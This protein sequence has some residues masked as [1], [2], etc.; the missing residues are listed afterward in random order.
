[1]S[2]ILC[3]VTFLPKSMHA[4]APDSDPGSMPIKSVLVCTDSTITEELHCCQHLIEGKDMQALPYFDINVLPNN[5][6][7]I[8]TYINESRKPEER[9]LIAVI[10]RALADFVGPERIHRREA[11]EFLFAHRKKGQKIIKWSFEWMCLIL[12]LNPE[13][14]IKQLIKYKYR[15]D[16]SNCPEILH[17]QYLFDN[18]RGSPKHR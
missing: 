13:I 6:D 5:V 16:F 7:F 11:R 14:F 10:L 17:I 3:T 12:N 8:D 2:G 1:M 15:D 4:I 18:R 9:L